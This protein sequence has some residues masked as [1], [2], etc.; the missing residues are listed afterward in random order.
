[1]DELVYVF[2]SGGEKIGPGVFSNFS[3]Q[4][5]NPQFEKE[6]EQGPLAISYPGNKREHHCLSI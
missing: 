1:M 6:M 3:Y 5:W 4:C 2:D